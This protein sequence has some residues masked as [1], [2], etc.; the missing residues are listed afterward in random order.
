MRYVLFRGGAVGG[1]IFSPSELNP[2]PFPRVRSKK[3]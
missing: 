2:S 1:G 3:V